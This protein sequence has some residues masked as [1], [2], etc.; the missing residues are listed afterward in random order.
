MHD[1]VK[2]NYIIPDKFKNFKNDEE[3]EEPDRKKYTGGMVI[4]P[5]KG[6]YNEF[7][8]LL[9][10]NSLYPSIIR[11]YNVCFSKLDR[12]RLQLS[13]FYKAKKGDKK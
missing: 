12:P 11:E 6:M 3:G 7:I 8:I 9:D 2:R 1:C 13:K 5:K 10:F 4:E